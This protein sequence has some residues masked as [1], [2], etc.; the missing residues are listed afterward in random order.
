LRKHVA[1]AIKADMSH[2][3]GTGAL[4]I[5]QCICSL[6]AGPDDMEEDEEAV[7]TVRLGNTDR[8]PSQSGGDNAAEGLAPSHSG[9]YDSAGLSTEGQRNAVTMH[10]CCAVCTTCYQLGLKLWIAF[11]S[12]QQCN[13]WLM[14]LCIP[15]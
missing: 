6:E 1:V 15:C 4:T 2:L 5:V 9:Q 11:R 3:V 8:E 10:V 13:T 14:H 7:P 12:A